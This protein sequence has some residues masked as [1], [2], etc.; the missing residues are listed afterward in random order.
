MDRQSY[1]FYTNKS[2]MKTKHLPGIL[3][4]FLC[5]TN[6][7]A[8]SDD[9]DNK[10]PEG[11]ITLNMMN[12]ENG[13][14]LLGVS[15]I[16][17]NKANNFKTSKCFIADMGKT[18]GLGASTKNQLNNLSQEI[19]VIP[20][21]LYH[22]YDEKIIQDFPSGNRAIMLG[23]GYYKVYIENLIIK[24]NITSGVTLKYILT[25]PE[26]NNLPENETNIG[27]MHNI[28]DYIEYP[29]PKDTE[30]S[31]SEHLD[32]HN[33]AFNIQIT[34]KKLKITQRQSTDSSSGPY[35]EYRI[36]IRSGST[37]TCVIFWVN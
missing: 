8:C 31:F 17:I 23:S 27:T 10:E 16:Y 4:L 26:T 5:T 14:T 11:S 15:D 21:H 13:K 19:A 37:F 29:L 2:T 34:E 35:G 18:S 36:Y 3:L 7:F 32:A 22:V 30:V 12:E 33:V 24:E 1:I 20:N 6:F 9:D 25:Y 28:G